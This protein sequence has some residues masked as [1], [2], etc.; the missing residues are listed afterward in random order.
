MDILITGSVA[1]DYLMTFSGKFKDNFL[2]D[3]LENISLSF[4]VDTLVRRRGGIAPNIAYTY[5]LLGGT[6]RVFA[7]VGEDFSDYR[8]WLDS[9]GVNTADLIVIPDKLT[10]S[11]FATTDQENAQLASFYPGAMAHAAEISLKDLTIKPDLVVISPNDPTAMDLYIDQCKDLA[12]DYVYDPSQQIARVEGDV[13]RKGVLSAKALFVNQY[14]YS[15]IQKKTGLS[16][17]EIISAVEFMV[18]TL[19]DKGAEIYVDGEVIHVD[20]IPTENIVDPTGAG[21]A[22]RG[23]FLTGFSRGWDW[24]TCAQLGS[25]A[26]TY[27]LESDGPQGHVYTRQEF[28]TRYREHVDDLQLLDKLI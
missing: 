24:D 3:Q 10:A 28:I 27:C 23:G 4:L 1:Y 16:P 14:E 2:P 21:D 26:A 18:I 5:A 15:L 9:K 19:G 12:L 17:E 7:T 8:A 11:F 6:P 25:L 22:F 20:A 13:L